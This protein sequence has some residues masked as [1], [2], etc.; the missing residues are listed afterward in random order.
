MRQRAVGRH[1]WWIRFALIGCV[2]SGT[3]AEAQSPGS[4]PITLNDAVQLAL[5]N[6][7]AIKESRDIVGD[8]DDLFY[9]ATRKRL[10]V[11]GGEGYLDVFQEQDANHFVRAAHIATAANGVGRAG[12]VKRTKESCDVRAARGIHGYRKASVAAGCATKVRRVA[13][14]GTFGTQLGHKCAAIEVVNGGPKRLKRA[15]RGKRAFAFKG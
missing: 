9:D 8:T 4:G 14:A 7:P 10:Y 13:E 1:V 15:R 3:D 11:T 2:L 12:E 6:Y 5:K